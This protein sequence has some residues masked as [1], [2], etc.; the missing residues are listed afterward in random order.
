MMLVT[1][2]ID[3]L[4]QFIKLRSELLRERDQVS[5]RLSQINNALGDL[6]APSSSSGQVGSGQGEDSGAQSSGAGTAPAEGTSL[7]HHVVAV[8]RDGPK[9]KEEVLEAVQNRGYIF[10][11]N[12]PL[13]SLGVIL[14]GK[15]PKLNRANGRFS[16][17]G[18]STGGAS[19]A[20]ASSGRG[21]RRQMSPAARARIAEAQRKRWAAARKGKGSAT[22]QSSA[23][24]SNDGSSGRRQISAAGRKAIAEAARRRWAAAKAAGKSRL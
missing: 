6:P 10:H 1:M 4:Q 13:N 24:K 22:T 11:T 23:A 9:T 17:S 8:L 12:K 2:R 20:K 16:L 3:T 15:N 14:Y 19:E 7:R 21:G 5:R 18:S